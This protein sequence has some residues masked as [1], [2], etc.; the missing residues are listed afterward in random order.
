MEHRG[1]SG[2]ASYVVGNLIAFESQ[3]NWHRKELSTS[4]LETP[5]VFSE[6]KV[7]HE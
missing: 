5:L 3:D 4:T 6:N 1:S 2:R 7:T